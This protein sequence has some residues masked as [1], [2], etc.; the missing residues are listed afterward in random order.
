MADE[1]SPVDED[2]MKDTADAS[3]TQDE[4]SNDE[5]AADD[6]GLTDEDGVESADAEDGDSASLETQVEE[7]KEALIRSQADLQNV[8]RRAER[9]VENAHKYAVEKF[10]KDLLAVLDSMDRA[11]ELAETTEGFD[12]AML[13]GTQMTHKLL[14]DTAAKHGVEPINPVGEA[15]DPQ[16]H[17]AMSMVESADHEPNTVMA[18]MQKG[19]KLE[20]RVIRAAMVMVTKAASN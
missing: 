14:L 4:T 2:V 7:L 18:V 20:G 1:K 9:D 16:E 11:L 17:Q 15:F 13:E 5:V 10:V 19:Y 6:T 8:R 12:A 3:E